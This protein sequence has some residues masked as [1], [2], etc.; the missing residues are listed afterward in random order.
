MVP[1]PPGG[2]RGWVLVK[3]RQLASAD[4]WHGYPARNNASPAVEKHGHFEAI[5]I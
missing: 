5:R 4:H 1:C 3:M 2:A